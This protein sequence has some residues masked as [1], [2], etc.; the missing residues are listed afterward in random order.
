MREVTARGSGSERQ[1]QPTYPGATQALRLTIR[2]TSRIDYFR[3]PLR[4]FHAAKE[5]M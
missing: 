2:K 3:L 5:S 1:V 4:A